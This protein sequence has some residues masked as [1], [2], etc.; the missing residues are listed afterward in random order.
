VPQPDH[1]QKNRHDNCQEI[2]AQTHRCRFGAIIGCGGLRREDGDPGGKAERWQQGRAV[3]QLYDGLGLARKKRQ[4]STH[5]QGDRFHAGLAAW[6]RPNMNLSRQRRDRGS[7]MAWPGVCASR[8]HG[9]DF[10]RDHH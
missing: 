9:I 6:M 10:R 3:A 1:E 8:D 7:G 4:A 5:L 2:A